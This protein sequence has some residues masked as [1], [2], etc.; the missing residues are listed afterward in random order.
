MCMLDESTCTLNFIIIKTKKMHEFVKDLLLFSVTALLSVHFSRQQRSS[1]MLA[2][3]ALQDG[4]SLDNAERVCTV[5]P[6]NVP[7]PNG[8]TRREM[9]LDNLWHRAT[10]VVVRHDAKD[11]TIRLVVQRRSMQKDYCPGRLDPTPGGVVGYDETYR[12]NAV[13]ELEEEMGISATEDNLKRLFCFPYEDERVRVWGDLFEVYYDGDLKELSLQVEEVDEVFDMTLSDLEAKVE[14]DP[15]M[16]MPDSLYAIRLYLQ[17][18]RDH[19]L[20]RRLLRGYSSNI[21]AYKVRPKPQVVFFDCDDCLYFDNWKVAQM[22]TDSIDRWCVTNGLKEGQAYELYKQYGTALK[23]LLAEGYI[24]GSAEAIDD[25]LQGVHDID[26]MANLNRDHRLRQLLLE[27]DPSIPKYIFTAS[28]RDHA[29][30]CLKALGIDDLF[31][32]IVDVKACNLETKHSPSSFQ[33]AMRIAGVTNPEACVFL[34]DS[35][36]NINAAR[37]VGWRSILVGRVCRD[38]GQPITADDAEAEIDVIHQFPKV[39]PELF[40]HVD[41]AYME[42]PSCGS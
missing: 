40:E 11:K 7:I 9:R 8:H 34:D 5:T 35:V 1:S 24:D 14:S 31:V 41:G 27:M 32:D 10:Y 26:V 4:T 25:F 15:N 22:L 20:N 29:E 30:R 17:Y 16:W 42:L 23:G 6:A 12:Q 38:T 39:L 21:E 13:R 37:Q 28:V 18:R 2:T 3:K 36:R 33:A 19:H